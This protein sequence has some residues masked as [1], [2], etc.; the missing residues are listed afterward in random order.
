M[1]KK[2]YCDFCGK[3]M[4][5]CHQYHKNFPH[6]RSQRPI[7]SFRRTKWTCINRACVFKK[8]NKV[9]YKE[10]YDYKEQVRDDGQV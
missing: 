5:G 10:Y 7:L 3:E 1:T 4:K 2:R 6:G 9:A 8:N